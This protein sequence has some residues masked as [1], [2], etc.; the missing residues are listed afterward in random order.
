[1][2]KPETPVTQESQ[3]L[4]T[5]D[6]SVKT[7]LDQ[8]VAASREYKRSQGKEIS[9]EALART[10]AAV[11]IL[12]IEAAETFG[13]VPP[14]QQQQI[15]KNIFDTVIL[16]FRTRTPVHF[17]LEANESNWQ[18]MQQA[19]VD[20]INGWLQNFV[21]NVS[22]LQGMDKQLILTYL[23]SASAVFRVNLAELLRLGNRLQLEGGAAAQPLR[24]EE[25]AE[26]MQPVP[27]VETEKNQEIQRVKIEDSHPFYKGGVLWLS[28]N[29]LHY[30]PYADFIAALTNASA[31]QTNM[32]TLW[33]ELPDT[34]PQA[35]KC[36]FGVDE[37]LF[38]E[39][40]MISYADEVKSITEANETTVII[41][42]KKV[43]WDAVISGIGSADLDEDLVKLS[44]PIDEPGNKN[45]LIVRLTPQTMRQLLLLRNKTL[46]TGWG[47]STEP[48]T[49]TL[50]TTVGT[51]GVPNLDAFAPLPQVNEQTPPPAPVRPEP[52]TQPVRPVAAP[53]QPARVA[54]TP[55]TP[56]PT[57]VDGAKSPATPVPNRAEPARPAAVTQNIKTEVVQPVVQTQEPR[58]TAERTQQE[59]LPVTKIEFLPDGKTVRLNDD[60]S[61]T[62]GINYL[63]QRTNVRELF[64]QQVLTVPVEKRGQQGAI[65]LLVVTYPVWREFKDE[66]RRRATESGAQSKEKQQVPIINIPR[67][68]I[69]W[70]KNA[71]QIALFTEQNNPLPFST[72]ALIGCVFTPDA[73][74]PNQG[75]VELIPNAINNFP[76]HERLRIVRSEW[77]RIDA[78]IPQPLIVEEKQVRMDDTYVTL[79]AIRF[80]R[81]RLTEAERDPLVRNRIEITVRSDQNPKPFRIEISQRTWM[82]I[83][84]PFMTPTDTAKTQEAPPIINR[85]GAHEFIGRRPYMEDRTLVESDV[86]N[87]GDVLVGVFDGHGGSKVAEIAQRQ[88]A[89][90]MKKISATN[91]KN[92]QE[93]LRLSFLEVNK[94]IAQDKKLN[95]TGATAAVLYRTNGTLYSANLGDS[96]TV[97]DGGNNMAIRISKD[98]KADDPAEIARIEAAGGFVELAIPGADVARVMGSLAIARAL[99]DLAFGKFISAEAYVAAVKL[100]T[101]NSVAV[102]ACDG[103]WDV[104]TDDEAI[105]TITDLK[106]KGKSE[107][108]AAQKLVQMAYDR[109][110]GDNLTAVVVY[111]N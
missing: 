102:T 16:H 14:E 64:D 29:N 17:E 28:I 76:Q 38:L 56:A 95:N 81:I 104:I 72:E 10:R 111:L 77:E 57:K 66:V 49:Y 41:N 108:E 52:A 92:I 88:F 33:V 62:F 20:V 18:Q 53:A 63:N 67:I 2:A 19:T 74:D 103:I 75:F 91:P 6:Q 43:Q 4:P 110:S 71:K 98:H 47:S 45:Y 61:Q 40:M 69:P 73:S 82:K 85:I 54:P 46:P 12:L 59:Q 79:N 26:Q 106:R 105:A 9:T 60:P 58:Q 44:I 5:I 99:G 86:L 109:G 1:M 37:D 48:R 31:A 35:A 21:D 100:E 83:V 50:P 90:E 65:F 78:I 39:L 70:S 32:P 97:M 7:L 24:E 101:K 93:L 87:N 96:R 36:A 68:E 34:V 51:P 84:E 25:Q 94:I 15:I 107:K 30:V 22:Q 27:F 80:R 42:G 8:N 23:N 3:N 13:E 11:N 89:S 55:A